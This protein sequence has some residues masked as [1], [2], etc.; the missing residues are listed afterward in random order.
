M[1]IS[2]PE[3]PTVFGHGAH[4]LSSGLWRSLGYS[5]FFMTLTFLKQPAQVFCRKSFSL[6]FFLYCFVFPPRINR[7]SDLGGEC[8]RSKVPLF[9]RISDRWYELDSALVILNLMTWL[10]RCGPGFSTVKF[11]FFSFHN[12]R[13][14][15]T[16]STFQ[17][18]R[19]ELHF[20]KGDM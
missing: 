3:E 8:D 11:L 4:F 14:W 6:S 2:G 15:V 9:H 16:E 19:I 17:G 1:F 12:F 20:S 13:R 7:N 18:K 10:R 5:W